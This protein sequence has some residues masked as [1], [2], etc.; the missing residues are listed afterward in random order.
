MSIG[1]C[2]TR[3]IPL[4]PIIAITV[5]LALLAGSGIISPDRA[6]A[7]DGPL[8]GAVVRCE[9]G[10]GRPSWPAA[11]RWSLRRKCHRSLW[12]GNGSQLQPCHRAGGGCRPRDARRT[13]P[14][15]G[16]LPVAG[17]RRQA[18]GQQHHRHHRVCRHAGCSVAT[19]QRLRGRGSRYVSV[20][21]QRHL[22]DAV[23]RRPVVVI[24]G[25]PI[26]AIVLPSAVQYQPMLPCYDF[27]ND[28]V[29][30]SSTI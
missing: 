25:T 12:R 28:G 7:G 23:Y 1:G 29:S 20:G 6:L 2:G 17:F 9:P 16:W 5:L 14:T 10:S 21:C 19:R 26:P 30:T 3:R 24:D 8:T 11:H 15:V 27:D 4:R 13:D 18:F 22:F